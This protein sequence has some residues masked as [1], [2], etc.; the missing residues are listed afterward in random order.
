ML[1]VKDHFPVTKT[2]T[3]L[4]TASC[5]LFSN[6]LVEWRR[7]QDQ[8][9]L[10]RA[11]M[12]RDKHK[13]HFVSIR[14]SI[15]RFFGTQPDRVALLPNFSFGW[16]SLLEGL[17]ERS[18][19]L[20]I[21]NDYPSLSWPVERR[22]FQIF[23]TGMTAQL[24][25][26]ILEAVQQYK[27][28]ILLL[29]MVQY[30]SGIKIDLDFLSQLK[31]DHPGLLIVAD[32]TQYLGTEV[33]DFENGPID[34]I[35]ASA[36]KW[37]LAGHGNGFFL[38][39]PEAREHFKIK[40][41]GYNSADANFDKKHDIEFVGYLE[42]GHQDAMVYGSI[43][44]SMLLLEQWGMPAIQD[45]LSELNHEVAK[46]LRQKGVWTGPASQRNNPSTIFNIDGNEALFERMKEAG[47][48]A[49]QRGEGIRVSFHI[50]NDLQDLETLLRVL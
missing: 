18:R 30:V 7:L 36:Y 17:C 24:E 42:P 37:L 44:Q 31:K 35:G 4:N 15:A 40:T 28:D 11:S 20:M 47:I 19:F 39:K 8:Q 14:Q 12:F 46:A 34:V 33:Y 3:Y 13:P 45:H 16:N 2:H 6:S 1:A 10:N 23:R 49:S 29:S 27:P 32:G 43:E 26:N 5:G 21:N 50:Y 41:I 25:S 22:G 9:M 48:V 38:I